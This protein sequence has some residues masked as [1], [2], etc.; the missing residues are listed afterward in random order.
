MDAAPADFD[1]GRDLGILAQIEAEV[2]DVEAAL[3]RLESGTYGICEAC[4]APIEDSHLETL[5]ASRFCL[6]HQDLDFNR[7]ADPA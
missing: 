2:A 3:E 5:P 4:A 1:R 6:A 7:S